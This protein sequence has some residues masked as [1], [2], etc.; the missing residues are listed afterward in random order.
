LT[1]KSNTD[2]TFL[3]EA[4]LSHHGENAVFA[5]SS[6]SSGANDEDSSLSDV[7]V[8]EYIVHPPEKGE[9]IHVVFEEPEDE[10]EKDGKVPIIELPPTPPPPSPRSSNTFSPKRILHRAKS[11]ITDESVKMLA[12]RKSFFLE[13]FNHSNSTAE[14]LKVEEQEV[15]LP[16]TFPMPPSP[17]PLKGL[18]RQS[19]RLT[20]KGKKLTKKLKR[21]LSFHQDSPLHHS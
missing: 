4:P 21:A 9:V 1:D 15:K 2:T 11:S 20:L 19:S 13:K 7:S 14:T 5:S 12:R 18:R 3:S 6:S 10:P 8:T 17:P 16:D